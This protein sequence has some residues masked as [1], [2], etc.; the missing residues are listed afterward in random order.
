LDLD[1]RVDLNGAARAAGVPEGTVKNWRYR[2]WLGADGERHHLVF[3]DEGTVRLG[4]VLAAERDTRRRRGQ[5]HRRL[6]PPPA[7]HAA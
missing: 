5:S 3:D 7:Y 4:D 6:P 2:G 1:A